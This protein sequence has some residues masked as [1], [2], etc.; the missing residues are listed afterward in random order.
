MSK[1]FTTIKYQLYLLQ[2]ENYQLGRFWRL[3]FKKGLVPH[4]HLR[5]ELVW[6]PKAKGLFLMSLGL[7]LLVPLT[8]VWVVGLDLRYVLPLLIIFYFLLHYFFFVF[9]SLALVIIWPVDFLAK[10]FVILRARRKIQSLEG[11]KIIGIAGS[12]GKTTMKN[13]LQAVLREKT[14]VLATPESVNTPVGVARWILKE[15]SGSTKVL[16]VEMGEHYRGDVKYLCDITPPDV[17]VIT[18]INEAHLERMKTMDEIIATVFEI[19]DSAKPGALIVLNADDTNVLSNYQKFVWPDHRLA[20]YGSNSQSAQ[21]KILDFRFD[22]QRLGW[23]VILEEIGE[24]FISLLGGY[25]PAYAQAAA[26]VGRYW[27]MHDV[28]IKRGIEKIHPVEHRLQP[29]DSAGNVLVIDDSYNSNP[30]GAAEAVEVLSQFSDRR[31]IYITPGMVEMG[32]RTAQLHQALGRR[33]AKAAD[34]VILIK[35][36]VTPFIAEGLGEAGFKKDSIVWFESAQEA[37][38]ALKSILRSGDV[39]L[40]QND[41]GD[42]YL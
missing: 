12:Y 36:S 11:L 6:T 7:F 31:K 27:K 8:A 17:A 18:G 9:C 32:K 1:F 37:H 10:Q 33:L 28:E 35:N 15:V 40:F 26:I 4:R 38:S 22:R 25:A 16:I 34:V 41:W 30:N 19:V 20:F 14:E 42:Q 24:T 3:I 2:L 39:I 13:V 21:F 23:N 29:L 5:K